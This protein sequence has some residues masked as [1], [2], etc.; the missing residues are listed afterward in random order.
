MKRLFIFTFALV[1]SGFL[2][3]QQ[4]EIETVVLSQDDTTFVDTL[5]KNLIGLNVYP[6]LGIFGS[7]RMPA[8]KITLQYKHLYDKMNVR[9]SINFINFYRDNDYIDVIA[10]TSDLVISDGDTTIVDS[11]IF[12][13][14]YYN[15]YTYDI[16]F[17]AEAAFP[18]KNY[19]F[20]IG[21]GVIGGYHF[22]G[23][24][25][26]HYKQEFNGYPVRSINYINVIPFGPETLGYREVDFLKMGADLTIGVDMNISP[27]CVIS[28]QYAPELVYYHSLHQRVID[29]DNYYTNDV[30]SEFVFIPDYIDL[31]V[32]IRF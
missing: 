30:K 24:Y 18:G 20:Y 21:G 8:S 3:A 4:N 13:Q 12:R 7:G 27:N 23:E 29:P 25:Y 19:R 26:Y 22:N 17:G 16:R 31:I 32:S 6:A 9:G 1:I 28:L 15:Y 5:N 10:K 2:F 11:L 14:F